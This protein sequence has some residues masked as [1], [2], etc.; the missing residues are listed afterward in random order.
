MQSNLTPMDLLRTPSL[1]GA[2][3]ETPAPLY[4]AL[5][6]AL[7]G[8]VLRGELLPGDRLPTERAFAQA[9][10]LSRTTV[11]AAY[12]RLAADGWVTTRQGQGTTVSCGPP[13]HIAPAKRRAQVG[14]PALRHSRVGDAK[15]WIDFSLATAVP[16][17][18]WLTPSEHSR[19]LM[20]REN[21]Y[22]AEGMLALRQRIAARYSAQGLATNPEQILVCSGAQ[23]AISLVA[24]QY[25]R[26]GDSV[27]LEDPNY[28]GAIDVFRA[29]G[30]RLI[31]VPVR[32]H[33]AHA[34]SFVEALERLRPKL[35]YVCPGLHN[36]TGT[37][38]SASA[39][40]RLGRAAARSGGLLL[41]DDSL[42][43]LHFG[44]R[45]APL[46]LP[47]GAVGIHIGSLS[48]TLWAGLRI[49]WLRAPS[50][51]I[52]EQLRRAKV[53]ADIASSSLSSAIACDLLDHLDALIAPRRSSLQTQSQ[54][55]LQAL[56]QHLP[57]WRVSPPEGGLFLWCKL[58]P[59][60]PRAPELVARAE[61]VNVR[62]TPG[63]ALAVGQGGAGDDFI[64]LAFTQPAA[65]AVEGI[66]RL[67]T[68][69]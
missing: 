7:Q 54:Q 4:A 16:D 46:R 14:N 59:T 22:Q 67:A 34:Q 43:E 5:A 63:N 21:A 26:P 25:L 30:A 65:M 23:Q 24:Q 58:P 17:L 47:A 51:A 66:R 8:L 32:P 53:C 52:H 44:A 2:W 10:A 48:K 39:C 37:S 29:S 60:G 45:H 55:L 50:P 62:L 61:S 27:L 15:A 64:R 6:S 1:L 38:W 12:A 69:A 35:S 42:A 56:Q 9:L 18:A 41:I 19:N 40:A 57:N 49:G 68:L 31:A 36:P 33:A 3:R 13:G 11:V 28:F 20:L